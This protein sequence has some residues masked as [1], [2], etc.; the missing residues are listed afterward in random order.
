MTNFVYIGTSLDG[1]IASADGD[2]GWMEY[3]PNPDGDDLGFSDFME[4]IDAVVMGRN[5]FETLIG[6]DVGWHYPKPGIILSTTLDSVPDEFTE[7]VEIAS[8][9]P[10]EV[11]ELLPADVATED[12]RRVELLLID[13]PFAAEGEIVR[14]LVR[15]AFRRFLLTR[16]LSLRSSL[17][18]RSHKSVPPGIGS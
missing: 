9:T 15:K 2:F 8:G 7:H 11:I 14:L 13:D 12:R 4:R 17:R 5:T 6:F 18:T 10:A 3:V 1:R 16:L